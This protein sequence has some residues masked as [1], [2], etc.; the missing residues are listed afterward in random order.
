MS[1][2]RL[3]AVVVLFASLAVTSELLAAKKP[4]VTNTTELAADIKEWTGTLPEGQTFEIKWVY[5]DVIVSDSEDDRIHLAIEHRPGTVS[6][7]LQLL[8]H[9]QGLTLCA[10]YPSNKCEP[11]DR[12]QLFRGVKQNKSGRTNLTV[13]LPTT[14]RFA[15]RAAEGTVVSKFNGAAEFD[16]MTSFMMIAGGTD[17]RAENVTGTIKLILSPST[18][19]RR[20]WLMAMNEK[21][22]VTL[23]NV[24]VKLKVK[25]DPSRIRSHVPVK[26]SLEMGTAVEAEGANYKGEGAVVD[27]EVRTMNG[28]IIIRRE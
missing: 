11:G 25:G 28:E 23:Y 12:G 13:S 6:P 15:G 17:V 1:T 26:T 21:A 16:V 24:P 27:L 10:V 3:S 2:R 9:D 4:V 7:V 18:T 22:D 8:E 20:F 19:R 14:V 5:G